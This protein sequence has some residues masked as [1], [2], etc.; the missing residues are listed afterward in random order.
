M[1]FVVAPT[2]TSV[3]FAG[4]DGLSGPQADDG[5]SILRG[6]DISPG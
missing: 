4:A 6:Y 3:D 2:M 5:I 1:A